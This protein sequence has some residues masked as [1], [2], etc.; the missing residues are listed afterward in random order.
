MLGVSLAIGL[1]PLRLHWLGKDLA[2]TTVFRT[3]ALGLF[4]NEKGETLF[5]CVIGDVSPLHLSRKGVGRC[6]SE[7][8][9]IV[10]VGVPRQGFHRQYDLRR[11]AG[12]PEVG[13]RELAV[14]EK[15]VEN[16]RQLFVV[17]GNAFGYPK[18]VV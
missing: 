16:R 6:S 3:K 2:G 17:T 14:L 1:R 10:L 15:I 5:V 9:F 13:A 11:A 12:A 18:D 7:K 4:G 8:G